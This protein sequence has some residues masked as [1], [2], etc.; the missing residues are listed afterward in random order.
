M[1]EMSNHSKDS[2]DLS[3]KYFWD[4]THRSYPRDRFL[5]TDAKAVH[6]R[7]PQTFHEAYSCVHEIVLIELMPLIQFNK[8]GVHSSFP[9]GYV[10]KE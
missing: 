3:I 4:L 8:Y 6:Q 5:K 10:N 9:N 2:M 1:G 7:E